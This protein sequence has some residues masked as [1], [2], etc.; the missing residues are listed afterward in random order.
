MIALSLPYRGAR[1][2]GLGVRDYLMGRQLIYGPPL[3]RAA[4]SVRDDIE[5]RR[6]RAVN[7]ACL[8]GVLP[9]NLTK[10]RSQFLR[11]NDRSLG[12]LAGAY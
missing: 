5:S 1:A 6:V 8:A 11:R 9:T 12:R 10:P 7:G 4:D 3:L 2:I